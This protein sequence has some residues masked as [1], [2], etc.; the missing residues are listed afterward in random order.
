MK[1]I[2]TVVV[3]RSMINNTVHLKG[4]SADTV[5]H[6]SHARAQEM[7]SNRMHIL[8]HGLVPYNNVLKDAILIWSPQRHNT[9]AVIYD[10]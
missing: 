5:G 6:R 10:R 2:V 4:R 8:L 1:S 7:L 9:S 3:G